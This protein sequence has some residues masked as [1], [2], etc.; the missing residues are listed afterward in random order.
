MASRH[1]CMGGDK[2]PVKG[3]RSATPS[4]PP[5]DISPSASLGLSPSPVKRSMIDKLLQENSLDALVCPTASASFPASIAGCK[6]HD[7]CAHLPSFF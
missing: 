6:A 2:T 3:S 1:P 7:R 5:V 4:L